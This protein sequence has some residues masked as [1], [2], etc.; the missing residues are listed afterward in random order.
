MSLRDVTREFREVPLVLIDEPALPSRSAMDEEKLDELARSIREIG[1]QQPIIL[2]RVGERFEVV[3]GHRRRIASGRAGLIAVPSIVYPSR[4]DALDA[5]Q[6]A[7]NRHREELNPADE[8]LWFTELLEQKCSGD[9]EQLCGLVGE[10]LNYVNGRLELFSG[11]PDVFG[12]LREG[13]IRIGVA[14]ELNKCPDAHYRRYYLDCAVRGGATIGT[15]AGWIAEWRTLFGSERPS[16]PAPS[17]TPV[18]VPQPS[19][20]PH[21]CY[22]CGKSDPRFIP[23]TIL[24]HTHCK[25]AILEPLLDAAQQGGD[26]S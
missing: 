10:T 18:I 22:V 26:R 19:Q 1:L 23:E 25:H 17:V 16:A 13:R 20:D 2:A 15:V 6:F 7:E 5:V 24:V 8:A 21:R 3:A 9:I 14:H 12:A 11:D 4:T